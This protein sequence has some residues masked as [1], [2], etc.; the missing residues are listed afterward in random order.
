[1]KKIRLIKT[2]N[3]LRPYFRELV[4]G[5]V[6][7]Q[8]LSVSD[9]SCFYVVNLLSRFMKTEELFSWERDHYEEPALAELLSQ[10]LNSDM[11]ARIRVLKKMGDTSLYIA[12]YFSDHIDS[13]LVDIDYYVSMG[14]GAYKNLSGI[15]TGEKT[16]SE[17]YDELSEKFTSLVSVLSEVSNSG[18]IVSNKDLLRLYERWLKTGDKTV[19]E[20]LQKEG[21]L[22]QK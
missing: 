19:K 15:F 18:K 22:P 14:E 11:P 7:R 2:G 16:F 13:K 5:A 21:I 1:M 9:M 8:H 20:K 17:L 12:G 6:Y 4:E 10:A 3:D